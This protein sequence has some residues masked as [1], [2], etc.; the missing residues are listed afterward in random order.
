M[1]LATLSEQPFGVMGGQ[2]QLSHSLHRDQRENDDVDDH[3]A[4]SI[5][6]AQ[7]NPGPNAVIKTFSGSPFFNKL[8]RTNS[9]VGALILPW[10]RSTSRSTLSSPWLS[11]K[12]F[13]IA[14]ITFT[15]P[16][17]QQKRSI[18]ARSTSSSSQIPSTASAS[19]V[20]TNGGIARSN[21]TAKPESST[22]QPMIRSVSGQSRSAEPVIRA[23]L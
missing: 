7:V 23:R 8:S 15:P 3:G 10:S 19:S 5:I 18:V 11:F 2:P 14:S 22:S 17:W 20:S 4:S 12:A 16:G 1:L 6:P 13:S 9:T 21:T